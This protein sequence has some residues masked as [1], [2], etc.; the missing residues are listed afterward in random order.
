MDKLKKELKKSHVSGV[1]HFWEAVIKH[2]QNIIEVDEAS[3]EYLAK[4]FTTAL[5][6]HVTPDDRERM[7]RKLFTLLKVSII[8]DEKDDVQQSPY[9]RNNEFSNISSSFLDPLVTKLQDNSKPST[10]NNSSASS[11]TATA[12]ASNTNVAPKHFTDFDV[13][14]F[15]PSFYSFA[16]QYIF[17]F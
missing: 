12:V 2:L 7:H 5:V 15:F 8:P 4:C 6:Q 1:L 11:N 13:R 3:V 9:R 17:Y 14:L 16:L 10:T